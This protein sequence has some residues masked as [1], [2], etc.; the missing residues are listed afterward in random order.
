MGEADSRHDVEFSIDLINWSK[1]SSEST[2]S[3]GKIIIEVDL[4]RFDS[5]YFRAVKNE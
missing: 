4:N 1:L 2:D 5:Q 3:N